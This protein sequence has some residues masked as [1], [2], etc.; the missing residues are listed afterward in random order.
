MAKWKQN[1]ITVAAALVVAIGILFAIIGTRGI[2]ESPTKEETLRYLTDGFGIA[3]GMIVGIGLLVWVSTKGIFD[4]I[5]YGISSMINMR[6]TGNKMD[7]HKKETFSEYRDRKAEK[8]KSTIW[9]P[10]V[11]V[12]GAFILISLA[13]LGAYYAVI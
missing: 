7:W 11:A 1:L 10:I 8:R 5:G 3:G 2:F 9:I 4:G 6:W 13:I 12:G